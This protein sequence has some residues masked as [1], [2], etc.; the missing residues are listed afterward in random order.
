MND[1]G[2]AFPTDQ[3]LSTHGELIQTSDIGMSLW[4]YYAGQALTGLAARVHLEPQTYTELA[5]E[6]ADAMLK[7]RNKRVGGEG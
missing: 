4:D 7:E 3:V 1:G 6:I 5:C 2:P